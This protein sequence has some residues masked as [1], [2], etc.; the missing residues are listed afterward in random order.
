MKTDPNLFDDLAGADAVSLPFSWNDLPRRSCKPGG[1]ASVGASARWATVLADG[2]EI[3]LTALHQ[4]KTYEGVLCGLPEEDDVRAWPIEGAVRT[5]ERLFHYEPSR[6]VILP[7]ELMCSKVT[8]T[9]GGKRMELEI[10]FL[11]A[12]CSIATFESKESLGESGADG[13]EVLVVWFQ[14]TFGP[15]EPGHVT[16]SIRAIAW[17]RFA[18]GL[19]EL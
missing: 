9:R 6:V 7:P 17:D 5:A 16:D 2:R 13:G 14:G 11:P 8:T 12:V 1:Y 10:A 4:Y 3:W 18:C 19:H 15:P